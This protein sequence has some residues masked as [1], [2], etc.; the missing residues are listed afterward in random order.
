ML[1]QGTVVNNGRRCE[2][3]MSTPSAEIPQCRNLHKKVP[4]TKNTK[5]IILE[6]KKEVKHKAINILLQI[7]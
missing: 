1:Y 5:A 6:G 7:Y 4:E 3:S 2:L